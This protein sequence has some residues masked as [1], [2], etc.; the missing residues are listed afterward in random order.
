MRIPLLGLLALFPFM[1]CTGDTTADS[2]TS[3]SGAT[4]TDADADTDADSDSDT[5]ADGD[6]DSD[7]DSDTDADGDAD[8]DTDSDT[9]ADSEINKIQN[10]TY[11]EGDS[12]TFSG[13]VSS[14]DA[15]FAFF[16]SDTDGGPYSGVW[17]YYNS[18]DDW[19]HTVSQGDAVTITGEMLEFPEGSAPDTITEIVIAAH[20]DM[21]ITGTGT[22]P[23]P[24]VLTTSELSDPTTQ[25]MY[26][27]TLVQVRNAT[28]TGPATEENYYEWEVDSA[29]LVDDLFYQEIPEVG[30]TYTSITGPLYYSFGSFKIVPRNAGDLS[31]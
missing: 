5:D 21:S 18:A 28:V 2:G 19:A 11:K 29:V 17:V 3:D 26:E 9:D 30:A 23:D 14:P 1:A 16:V 20:A 15:G 10:G 12:V 25:E 22:L 27:S 24:T 8:G 31:K 6:S 4:A 13:V 7:S